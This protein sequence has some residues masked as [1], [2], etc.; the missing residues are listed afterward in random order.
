MAEVDRV[1]EP[2][3]AE[4]EFAFCGFDVKGIGWIPWVDGITCKS[5][6]SCGYTKG[7]VEHTVESDTNLTAVLGLEFFS[8][9]LH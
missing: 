5:L 8:V 7:G 9:D 2:G 1:S 6:A 4:F 3:D